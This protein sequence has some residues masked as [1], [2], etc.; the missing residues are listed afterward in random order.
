MGVL[1]EILAEE[2]V[3]TP[4]AK[5]AGKRESFPSA[6]TD[7][8]G[9]I[10]ILQAELEKEKK[11][12][13]DPNPEISKRAP[14]NI[15]AIS[16]EIAAISGKKM[17]AQTAQPSAQPQQTTAQPTGGVLDEIIQKEAQTQK[18][19][20]KVDLS[21]PSPESMAAEQQRKQ[22]VKAAQAKKESER[23]FLEKYVAPALEVPL[24][25]ATGI[26][27]AI[28]EQLTGKNI[29]YQPV[30]GTSQDILSDFQ[31]A[32]QESKLEG[33]I[34]L[35]TRPVVRA[36]KPAASFTGD[37]VRQ[38]MVRPAV[39]TVSNV[40]QNLKDKFV[41]KGGNVPPAELSGVGAAQ[42]TKQAQRIAKAK[43]LDFPIDLSRDQATRNPADVRFA[44][45]TAKDPRL[46][47]AFQEKYANDNAQ[48]QKNLNHYIEQTGAE[49]TGI[50]HGELGNK[51]VKAVEP[52]K[53][54]RKQQVSEAYK[55]AKIAGEMAEKVPTQELSNFVKDNFSAAKNAPVISSIRSE[56]KRLS[57]DGEITLNDAEELRKMVRVLSQDSGA[58]AHYAGEAIKIIDKI[59]EGKGGDFYK[60]ARRL[61]TDYMNEFENTPVIKNL[62]ATKP[63]T[64]KQTRSIAL[65]DV[66]EK[67]LIKGSLADTQALFNTLDKTPQGKAMINEMR[68]FVAQ[69][70]KDEATKGVQ[71]DINGLP[72]VS[73]KNLDT[74]INN[75]D[76]SG[77]LEFLFGKKG[78]EKYRTLN[79][80]TK[81]VQTVPQ[82][83]TNPSGTASTVIAALTEMGVQG[84]LTGVPAPYLTVGKHIYNK[85]QTK[86]QINKINEFI[87][88]GKDK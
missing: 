72:Y 71:L 53:K 73:T 37:V 21:I 18:P 86:K 32:F 8:A 74:I 2:K 83:T 39:E 38:D 4:A 64:N 77:K 23:G 25:I 33:A 85:V 17:P 28:S 27:G 66:V 11:N 88:Y 55:A 44:R 49:F 34:G 79:D 35:P 80:V 58:N 56:I 63:G 30:S 10:A 70:I 40:T 6:T 47:Q 54:E 51:L 31:R 41:E 16:R 68:G 7:N 14:A 13:S 1:D 48:I 43:E 52:Y 24:A 82:G 42:A 5:P 36:T 46:G 78:A 22:D 61:N 65:E 50:G 19:A 29:A 60:E 62:F 84:A 81:D 87:N 26:P 9:R 3:K 45:E 59:T 76:K 69:K 67:S 12:L 15:D 57:K 75:L 20:A